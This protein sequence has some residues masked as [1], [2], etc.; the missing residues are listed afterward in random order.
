MQALYPTNLN[1]NTVADPKLAAVNVN[2]W[3]APWNFDMHLQSSSPAIGAGTATGAPA[4]DIQGTTR[5]N[6]PS[7]GAYE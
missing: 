5:A 2:W 6:P 4:T 3:N 7:I 1:N